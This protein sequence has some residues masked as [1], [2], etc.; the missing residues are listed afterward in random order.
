MKRQKLKD[1]SGKKG[2]PSTAR[3]K[4]I[5]PGEITD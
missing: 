3:V 4:N 5:D 1:L 2:I